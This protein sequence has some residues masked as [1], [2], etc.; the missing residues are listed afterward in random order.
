M[1]SAKRRWSAVVSAGF[2]RP[3]ELFEAYR[4][5]EVGQRPFWFYLAGSFAVAVGSGVWIAL[6]AGMSL[7]AQNAGLFVGLVSLLV[8]PLS[9]GFE[10]VVARLACRVLSGR[11]GWR[12]T[13]AAV[14]LGAIPQ[15]LC[16]VPIV[17]VLWSYGA[18]AIGLREL[19]QLKLS[20]AIV[21]A[22]TPAAL[23]MLAALSFR[24]FGFEAFIV[25]S[26]SMLPSVDVGDHIYVTDAAHQSPP[27]PKAAM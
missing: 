3:T 27:P 7:S 5:G 24:Q 20:R 26:G 9:W 23:L 6:G 16:L 2:F 15:L 12:E 11:G 19:H 13:R 14:G 18:R 25:P 17:G 10:V 1:V 8:A 22:L 4:A 21:A